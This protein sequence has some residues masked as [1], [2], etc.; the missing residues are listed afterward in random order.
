MLTGLLVF[1]HAV[2]ARCML[3]LLA[4]C[5]LSLLMYDV[6]CSV[7]FAAVV[8]IT[9]LHDTSLLLTICFNCLIFLAFLEQAVACE[10]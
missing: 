2:F 4:R 7:K 1:K 3:S 10:P 5:M 9:L 8:Q 6:H